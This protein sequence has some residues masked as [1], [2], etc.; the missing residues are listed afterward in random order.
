MVRMVF[1]TKIMG[2]FDLQ[3]CVRIKKYENEWY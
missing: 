3:L 1:A 2:Y